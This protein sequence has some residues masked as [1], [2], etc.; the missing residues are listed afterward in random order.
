MDKEL[1]LAIENPVQFLSQPQQNRDWDMSIEDIA[2]SINYNPYETL[3]TKAERE[4]KKYNWV[5][6]ALRAIGSSIEDMGITASQ[7][8]A[9]QLGVYSSPN[10]TK[11]QAD[12]LTEDIIY[13]RNFEAKARQA[14]D[15]PY[16]TSHPDIYDFSSGVGSFLGFV[17]AELTHPAYGTFT[18]FESSRGQMQRELADK[19]IESTGSVEGYTDRKSKDDMLSTGYALLN[20]AIE[21]ALGM[22]KLVGAVIRNPAKYA[23]NLTAQKLL[24]YGAKIAL[25]FAQEAGEEF[26][27]SYLE[28]ATQIAAGYGAWDDLLKKESFQKAIRSATMGGIVGAAA[29]GVLH[30]VGRARAKA[31]IAE[32]ADKHQLNLSDAEVTQ[33]TNAIVDGVQT[34]VLDDLTARAEL[35]MKNGQAF[36]TLTEKVKE[37]VRNTGT[38]MAEESL[39]EYARTVAKTLQIPAQN[40]SLWSALPIE[41]YLNAAEIRVTNGIWELAP[42][43]S[44]ADVKTQIDQQNAIIKEQNKLK[45]LG[46]ENTGVLNDA[47]RRKNVLEAI[48]DSMVKE[49]QFEEARIELKKKEMGITPEQ[50]ALPEQDAKRLEGSQDLSVFVSKIPK[51]QRAGLIQNGTLDMPAVRKRYENAMLSWVANN[52]KKAFNK[53]AYASEIPQRIIEPLTL[54]G[55]AIV[56]LQ[57]KYPDLDIRGDIYGALQK[58]QRT[59][60]DNFISV[61]QEQELN[62]RDVMPENVMLWN[63]IF[64]NNTTIGMFLDNYTKIASANREMVARG[65]NVAPLSKKDLYAQALKQTDDMRAQIAAEN[66]STY[67]PLFSETGE[68]KDV[69]LQ[70]A[71]IS[72]QNQ[73]NT[74]TLGQTEVDATPYESDTIVVDDKERTVYNSNG[75]R[76]AKSKEALTNFWKWFGDSK[77]VDEQGRPLVVYHGSETANITEFK[78]KNFFFSQFSDIA[79]SYGTSYDAEK[80]EGIEPNIYSVYLKIENPLNIRDLK[81]FKSVL[82]SVNAEHTEAYKNLEKLV[83]NQFDWNDLSYDLQSYYGSRESFEN[84]MWTRLYLD[85][86]QGV[87]NYAK[88][89]GFD[90][91]MDL[92]QSNL[93]G[94][95]YNGFIVF[96]PTQ[97]KSVNNRGTYDSRTPNIYYQGRNLV[98]AWY[99]PD[100]QIIALTKNW[101]NLSL[102]HEMHHHYL[103]KLL[104]AYNQAEA[105]IISLPGAGKAEIRNLFDML[106][107]PDPT[108]VTREQLNI[109]QERFAS[110]TEAYLT[111]LGVQESENQV[112]KDFLKW[113]PEKYKSI[114][115]IGYL[116][117]KNEIVNPLLDQN[118]IDFFNKWFS[119]PQMPALPTSPDSQSLV[120]PTDEKDEIIPSSQKEMNDREIKWGID[121][122]EQIDAD[123][124]L[125]AS[126]DENTEGNLRAAIDGAKVMLDAQ[127]REDA[128]TMPETTRKR[129]FETGKKDAQQRMAEKAREYVAKNPEHAKELALADPEISTVYDA[130]IDR[131][132]LIRAVMETVDPNSP[133][134]AIMYDNLATYRSM[135]GSTLGL[136]NDMSQK[137][138]LDAK[139]EIENAREVKAAINYAGNNRGAW[140]KWTGDIQSFINARVGKIMQTA[141]GSEERKVALR[142]FLEEAKTKFSANTTDSTLN[143]LDLTGVNARTK[144]VFIKWA[145][146][147]IR[148]TAGVGLTNEQQAKLIQASTKAQNAMLAIDNPDSAMA[149]AAA[150]DLRNWQTVKDELKK[151]NFGRFD[152]FNNAV[153]N[154]MGGYVPSA[155]LMSFNTLFVA[156]IPSTAI[157]NAIVRSSAQKIYGKQAVSKPVLEAEKKRIKDVFS[158]SGMNLA[159]MEKP[160]SPSLMHGE[161]Y[162]GQ[163][164]SHWYDFTFKILGWGDNLFRIPTFVDTLGRIASK[165]ANGDAKLATEKFRQ[166]SQLNNQDEEAQIARKQA[167]AVA[168]MAVFTQDGTLAAGL[169]HVRSEINKMSRGLLGLEKE[170]FGLGN[171]LSPF[172]KTGANVVEM[173]VTGAFAPVRQIAFWLRQLNGKEIPDL[174]K[175]ALR[176]DWK[177]F[178][179]TAVSVALLSA[180]TSDDEELYIEPYE[181]GRKYDSARPYDSINIA[182]AWIK[183]D[184]FG[185]FST[186]IRIAVKLIKEKSLFKA[187]GFGLQEA[188]GETPLLNQLTSDPSYMFKQPEKWAQGFVYSNVMKFVPAQL[189]TVTKVASKEAGIEY[190]PEWAGKYLQR[191]FNRNYG[192]DG[193]AP[194]TND[195]I[196]VLTNRLKFIE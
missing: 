69:N 148:Q 76:I 137:A 136:T 84:I 22:E 183:L 93:G 187:Y 153:N 56:E 71:F 176:N 41:E 5:Q 106:D 116:N 11:E 30:R 34:Q 47:K 121:S 159:Q 18:M 150:R 130:P 33:V 110:M 86:Q 142:A 66:N 90:G 188:M 23:T 155:M 58:Y 115:N 145:E 13:L 114:L 161:K 166:Y 55:A 52:D 133:E 173:G 42:I 60:K 45:K 154:L 195:W 12:R 73:F 21:R 103:A 124:K 62:G 53:L 94:W 20:T 174:Q 54:H 180:L 99:D 158:A 74:P 24:G 101:N 102:V 61:M 31:A 146:K 91:I 138:Y 141:A 26:P 50:D 194:T 67:E 1:D 98:N 27:Q 36:D 35:K 48:Y 43:T 64:T 120:N 6:T 126:I 175:I 46:T 192:F 10:M 190:K 4:P 15:L 131:A 2:R 8:F 184:T 111:G 165:N 112:Y 172:L 168:N 179:W 68:I 169:N 70:S 44:S 167:L 164:K 186:P 193:V 37:V 182:G 25:G 113:I 135:S 78:G 163:D 147:A 96:D 119:E 32:W 152:K 140:D 88:S 49:E 16:M 105:G 151:A 118:A 109:A 181:Y 85:N 82:D 38:P 108:S 81:T 139:R 178:A 122:A 95:S 97:I 128:V 87:I 57:A 65:D 129:W 117:E 39:D 9:D 92:E 144:A 177:V 80:G 107:I 89:N 100:L 160:T 143:Q 72:Y 83:N 3:L 134:Y 191:R 51:S 28:D 149:S 196:N 19:Y 7:S 29:G 77:V 185:V 123:K 162:M 170:G 125:Y 79:G 14:E 59:T 171:L 127:P 157:N 132:W 189:K 17:L 156:N 40:L 104:N 63:F 75:D